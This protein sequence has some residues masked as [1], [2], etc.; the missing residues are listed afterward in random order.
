MRQL[1][2]EELIAAVLSLALIVLGI[3]ASV[4][5][6]RQIPGDRAAPVINPAWPSVMRPTP[7]H[8]PEPDRGDDTSLY[9]NRGDG[10][11]RDFGGS[12]QSTHFRH[13]DV[14]NPE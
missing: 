5:Y 3:G 8:L 7:L 1:A 13:C 9:E 14:S 12:R 6:M 11:H 10:A 2:E 4:W